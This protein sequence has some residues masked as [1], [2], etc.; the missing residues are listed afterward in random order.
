M[1]NFLINE[2]ADFFFVLFCVMPFPL[3]RFDV[4]LLFGRKSIRKTDR[5]CTNYQNTAAGFAQ[6]LKEIGNWFFRTLGWQKWRC[7]S[8]AML[9]QDI[10][11]F[12]YPAFIGKGA[13]GP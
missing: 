2:L 4:I 11:W 5:N 12:Y 13:F 7:V 6:G 3:S 8:I 10:V 1:P 9:I